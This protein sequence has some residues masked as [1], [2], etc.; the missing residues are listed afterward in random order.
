[1]DGVPEKQWAENYKSASENPG[2]ILKTFEEHEK[3]GFISPNPFGEAKRIFGDLLRVAAQAAFEEGSD[4][5]R[6]V[7]DATNK[8]AVNTVIRVRDQEAV[9]MVQDYIAAEALDGPLFALA[10]DIPI[11][12]SGRLAVDVVLFVAEMCCT[13]QRLGDLDQQGG[14]LRRGLGLQ[15]VEAHGGHLSQ[16]SLPCGLSIW[17]EMGFPFRR[18]LRGQGTGGL[19]VVPA[20][21]V[22]PPS[23]VHQ[24]H[25]QVGQTQGRDHLLMDRL[26]DLA[27]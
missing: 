6:I 27:G 24:G 1:M 18:R 26:R 7:H 2:V 12:A 15:L 9:P 22:H 19:D 13:G 17:V 16:V 20:H 11:D 10:F 8:V 23:A 4:E 3:L 14:H 25:P 5:W 21:Y